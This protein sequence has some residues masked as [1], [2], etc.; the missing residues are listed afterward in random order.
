VQVQFVSGGKPLPAGYM[1][2]SDLDQW[3]SPNP[4][5]A[6]D[7]AWNLGPGEAG[8]DSEIETQA[9]TLAR[10]AE[11]FGNQPP[12]GE[13]RVYTARLWSELATRKK[14]RGEPW[15]R[16]AAQAESQ[17]QAIRG[18]PSWAGH[19]RPVEERLQ[20]LTG[21]GPRTAPPKDSTNTRA[22]LK[23]A[24]ELRK[25]YNYAEAERLVL[26]VLQTE[27]QNSEANRLLIE[28]RGARELQDF[29]R[30]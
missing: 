5:V 29:S 20:A 2:L 8:T 14:A 30:R 10:V 11:R 13:A 28:I 27:P 21:A 18:D 9:A 16:D 3:E 25:Q 17:L 15:Q 24:I 7:L 23:T 1:R 6:L 22:L 26:R 12:A 19:V 4:A